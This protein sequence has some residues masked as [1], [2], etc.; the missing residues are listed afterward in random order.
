MKKR[1]D[2]RRDE[3]L[4]VVHTLRARVVHVVLGEPRVVAG[5]AQ[6]L[7]NIAKEEQEFG[8]GFEVVE[9]LE[10]TAGT[11]AEGDAVLAREFEETFGPKRPLEVAM[12][13]NLR[14]GTEHLYVHKSI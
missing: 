10:R 11:N 6:R 7:R 4:G 8:E 9:V 13:L 14:E 3:D 12:Q 5:F 1:P 2:G